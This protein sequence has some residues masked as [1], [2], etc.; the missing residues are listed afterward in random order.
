MP[1]PSKLFRDSLSE[2]SPLVATPDPD[3]IDDIDDLTTPATMFQPVP[4]EATPPASPENAPGVVQ[5]IDV[6]QAM[7]AFSKRAQG[8]LEE[9]K[10]TITSAFGQMDYAQGALARLA[11]SLTSSYEPPLPQ[12]VS[13]LEALMNDGLV[14]RHYAPDYRCEVKAVTPQGYPVTLTIHKRDA[15]EYVRSVGQ[16]AEWLK[17]NGYTVPTS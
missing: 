13:I 15:G 12:L 7:D 16:L 6:I 10:A 8:A 9:L 1:R 11:A 4:E 17:A 2:E 14:L 3:P 5:T